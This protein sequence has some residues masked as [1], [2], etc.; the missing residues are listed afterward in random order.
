[1]YLPLWTSLLV[2]MHDDIK[3]TSIGKKAREAYTQ[4][5]IRLKLVLYTIQITK[6]YIAVK[7]YILKFFKNSINISVF[8]TQRML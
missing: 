5:V 4:A 8:R 6:N 7:I 2:A 3:N 1:M